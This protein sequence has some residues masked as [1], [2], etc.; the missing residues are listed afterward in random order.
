MRWSPM[1]QPVGCLGYSAVSDAGALDQA[2]ARV[3]MV[4]TI[5]LKMSDSVMMPTS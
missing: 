3:Y 5:I 4:R 1:T 2:P